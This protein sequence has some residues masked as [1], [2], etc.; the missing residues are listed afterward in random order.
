[1]FKISTKKNVLLS[2]FYEIFE[3]FFYFFASLEALNMDI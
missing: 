3:L 1:M 2:I